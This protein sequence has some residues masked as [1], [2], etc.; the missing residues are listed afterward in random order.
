MAIAQIARGRHFHSPCDNMRLFFMGT[1]PPP[2]Q[3]LAVSG[4]FW[5]LLEITENWRFLV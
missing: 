4:M 1:S 3:A 2:Q 5:D